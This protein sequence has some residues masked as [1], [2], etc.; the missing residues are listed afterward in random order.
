[1][2]RAEQLAAHRPWKHFLIAAVVL[3]ILAA[4]VPLLWSTGEFVAE[5][6]W[7]FFADAWNQPFPGSLLQPYAGYFHVLPRFI[8]ELFS[9]L[10]ISA[11][12]YAYAAS[13]LALNAALI[14]I[15]YL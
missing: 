8:A 7:V 12:P 14:A 3:A 11:Q 4:R 1:M 9:G 13:G 2:I 10:P 5:D 15:F 6:G